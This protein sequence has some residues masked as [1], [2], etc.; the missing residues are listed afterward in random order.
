MIA[1]MQITPSPNFDHRQPLEGMTAPTIDTIILHYTGMPTADE[2]MGRMCNPASEVSAHY[3]IYEDGTLHQLVDPDFRAWHAGVS[4][5][6]GREYLNHSS[7]GI[8]LVNPGHDHGYQPFPDA[9]I[10]KLMN[11]LAAL[12]NRYAIEEHRF[13]GHSDV[14]P[15]RKI[16]PGELFPWQ[17]LAENGFGLWPSGNTNDETILLKKDMI[18][19]DVASLNRSLAAVGYSVPVQEQFSLF[20][21]Q[22][23]AAFQRHWRPTCVNALLDVGTS[24]ALLDIEKKML[25]LNKLTR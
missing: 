11:L 17:T 21:E 12:A 14:A 9:Q 6:Q 10:D 2:A 13:I 15:D 5:W 4:Y 19:P 25:L 16:D 3:C 1:G 24:N 8:E 18:G 20:T 7:I 23:L 22:A